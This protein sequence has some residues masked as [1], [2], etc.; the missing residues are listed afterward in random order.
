MAQRRKVRDYVLI[1]ALESLPATEFE[2]RVWRVVRGDRDPLRTS[3]PGGRWDDGTF[4]VLYTSIESDGALAEMHF[5]LMRGQPVFP[6]KM[7]FRLFELQ[8]TLRRALRLANVPDL[9]NLGIKSYGSL[10]YAR[11]QEE[12]PRTQEV[13][14]AT[15]F[16]GF[17]GLI[18]PSARSDCLNVVIFITDR[19]PPEALTTVQDHGVVDWTDWKS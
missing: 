6:S 16:L 2:G 7:E 11:K 1:D 4:D 14:E 19:S 9:E 8:V 17:D 15:R 10:E 18:V 5:H 13:G 3:S 12:Y